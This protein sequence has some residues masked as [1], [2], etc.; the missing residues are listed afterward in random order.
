MF[1]LKGILDP[2]VAIIN[3]VI[4]DKSAA[5]AAE[6][7]LKSMALSSQ[8][9]EEFAQLT[10]ITTAQT[11]I[12]KVEAASGSTFVAG[13]RPFILWTC[14][15]GFA[16]MLVI[17]PMLTWIAALCGHPI[18]F[19]V[20]DGNTLMSLTFGMLGLGAFRSFDKL[21]G[22]DTKAVGSSK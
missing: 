16:L 14:G 13:A 22:T 6:A 10:A 21:K 8:L 17:G 15:A 12:N 18:A 9:Q 11:D 20:L 2:I 1:D 7:Q 4:P 5:A 3:K 19:P